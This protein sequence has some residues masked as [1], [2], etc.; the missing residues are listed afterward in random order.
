[1]FGLGKSKD[2]NSEERHHLIN[3]GK[4]QVIRASG[5]VVTLDE[6]EWTIDKKVRRLFFVTHQN[7]ELESVHAF[8]RQDP[9]V[10]AHIPTKTLTAAENRGNK[11]E[12]V[13]RM[14]VSITRYSVVTNASSLPS[15]AHNFTPGIIEIWFK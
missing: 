10:A 15:K 13:A 3:E 8:V 1:M 11:T 2:K 6:D 9:P 7:D 5:E 12:M 4:L 14:T